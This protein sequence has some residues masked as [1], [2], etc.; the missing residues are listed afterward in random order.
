MSTSGNLNFHL[1]F[2]GACRTNKGECFSD[3]ATSPSETTTAAYCDILHEYA[4]YY[5][6]KR[7]D[8]VLGRGEW[9]RTDLPAV[10]R[11]F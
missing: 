6:H 2:S 1:M 5:L 4:V 7:Y 3:P 9:H 8:Y 11:L 10:A